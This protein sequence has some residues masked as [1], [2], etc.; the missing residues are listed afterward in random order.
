MGVSWNT[1]SSQVGEVV[2]FKI[3]LLNELLSFY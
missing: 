1:Y 2:E 3:T